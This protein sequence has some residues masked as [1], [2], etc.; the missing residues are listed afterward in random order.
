MAWLDLLSRAEDFTSSRL[1][2]RATQILP[3]EERYDYHKTF[4]SGSIHN[5]RRREE[6]ARDANELEVA[7]TS[8]RLVS[9]KECGGLVRYA[10]DDTVEYFDRSMSVR[11]ELESTDSLKGWRERANTIVVGTKEQFGED[12][13]NS[14]PLGAKLIRSKDYEIRTTE[15]QIIVC[16]FDEAGVIHGLFHLQSRMNLRE[17]PLLPTSL[18]LVRNSLYER[19]IVLSWLGWMQFPDNYLN[20]LAHDGYDA[21][22]ASVY[23]NPNG[24]EGPAHYDTIRKQDAVKLNDL[25]ARASKYGI[26]VYSALMFGINDEPENMQQLRKHIRDN[27]AIAPGLKGYILLTEGFLYKKFYSGRSEKD[28]FTVDEWANKWTEAVKIVTE[29][30]HRVDP[31]IEVLPWEYNID[32]RPERAPLKRKIV[33]L[34]PKE[35]I[36]LLTWENGKEFEIDG[37]KGFLRDYSINQ[38]GPAEVAKAQIEEAKSRGMKVYCKADCYATWQFGTIPYLPCVQQWQKRYSALEEYDVD[39]TLESWSNGY[40]PNFVAEL[41]CWSSWTNAMSNDELLDATAR[42]IFGQAG[43]E[44]AK[45]AWEHFSNAIQ[46]VPDTGPSM[47]TNNAVAHPLFFQEPPPRIMTMHNSWWDEEKKTPWRHKMEEAWPYAHRMMVFLPDFKNRSNLAE[48]YARKRS[49][50]E[51]YDAS[52]PFLPVFQKYLLLAAEELERGLRLY[53]QAAMSAP[54]EKQLA[55]VKEVLIAEQMRRMLLS[56]N[57]I[58]EFE[59][60]RL[61]LHATKHALEKRKILDKLSTILSDEI[62]RTEETY[63]TSQLDSRL[64]YELEMDYVY[65]P[66]VIEQKLHALNKTLDEEISSY[67]KKL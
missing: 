14:D 54:K 37:L 45:Q 66:F 42:R 55:A 35:S 6:T 53:R 59:S 50:V 4:L 46:L 2:E 49:G 33:S 20:H 3:I 13:A 15:S 67:R 18:K 22:F 39:G 8:W 64:G 25:V 60:K 56:L 40:K 43:V 23:A 58:L 26:H 7:K 44:H 19:R 48:S 5:Y 17:A 10:C 31:A 34:L 28:D 11:I 36:P 24:V 47:G 27:L 41:R 57:A 30:C 16:G 21:I 12:S 61:E 9:L 38:I 62:A 29:E 32:F 52:K 65:R 63:R 1:L 51:N